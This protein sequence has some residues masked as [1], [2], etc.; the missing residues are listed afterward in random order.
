MMKVWDSVAPHFTELPTAFSAATRVRGPW[1]AGIWTLVE[2][3]ALLA[4]ALL[5]IPNLSP[6]PRSLALMVPLFMLWNVVCWFLS[7]V[8]SHGDRQLTPACR[9]CAQGLHVW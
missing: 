6:E 1:S 5:R 8:S 3:A 7:D 4:I 2:V 9:L